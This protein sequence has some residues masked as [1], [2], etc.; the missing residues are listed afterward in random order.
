MDDP[1]NVVIQTVMAENFGYQLQVQCVCDTKYKTTNVVHSNS[2]VL[3]KWYYLMVEGSGQAISEG[4][5]IACRTCPLADK[6]AVE[7]QKTDA[8]NEY[9]VEP[10]GFDKA[11]QI[12]YLA[13]TTL[14]PNATFKYEMLLF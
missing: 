9:K 10:I 14:T 6:V 1:K 3:N 13:E 8:G 12:T 11:D 5:G 7:D 2:G 4:S